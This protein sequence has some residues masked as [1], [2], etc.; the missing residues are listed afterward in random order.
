MPQLS[1]TTSVA[2]ALTLLAVAE[3]HGAARAPLLQAAGLAA[4]DLHN[5]L[6]RIA[7]CAL[8]RLFDAAAVQ[9]GLP[10]IGLAFGQAVR[11]ASFSGLGFVA[12]TCA[13]LG[14]AIALIP[15]FG[16]LVFDT[17]RNEV[18]VENDG[19]QA[20]LGEPP[21][22]PE[23]AGCVGLDDAVLAGWVSYGRW[24]CGCDARPLQVEIRHAAPADVRPYTEL[25]GCPVLFGMPANTL[26][27]SPAL[28]QLPV[29]D[30]DP[31]LHRAMLQEA[32]AQLDRAFAG[33]SLQHRVRMLLTELLPQGEGR[34]EQ[35]AAR[36]HLAPRTLQRRLASEG[37]SFSQLLDALRRELVAR[38]LCDAQMSLSDI[39]LLLGFAE[40]SSFS[41]AFRDWQGCTPQEYR[42]RHCR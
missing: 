34:L 2:Y 8:A 7:M 32:Q 1:G 28:L 42:Q 21:L 35:V 5:P 4:E 27:F 29:R 9:T 37:T 30:A 19:Q 31:H 23:A 20:R 39:A 3:R 11:P 24:I 14:E 15:R 10:H 18:L 17:G 25:F 26:I 13:N 41:H 33:L 6:A 36:L 40:Q 16:R 12:M 22:P 38:Y